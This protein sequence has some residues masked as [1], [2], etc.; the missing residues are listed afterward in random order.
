MTKLEGGAESRT[1]IAKA[2]A[3]ATR[4]LDAVQRSHLR[5]RMNTRSG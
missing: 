4:A 5:P 1:L 2:G 3:L